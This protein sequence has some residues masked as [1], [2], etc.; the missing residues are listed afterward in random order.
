MNTGYNFYCRFDVEK[1]LLQDFSCSV[2]RRYEHGFDILLD[3]F[4]VFF[5]YEELAMHPL[6]FLV[7][8]HV[9]KN[10][11]EGDI[12]TIKNN[13]MKLLA[14]LLAWGGFINRNLYEIKI[15]YFILKENIA[16]LRKT[17]KL[18]G[19]NSIIKSLALGD[20]TA[21]SVFNGYKAVL[22]SPFSIVNEALTFVGVG[23]GLT[24]SFDDYLSGILFVDR[25]LGKNITILPDDFFE[26]IKIKTTKQ[27]VQQ[28]KY[29]NLGKMSLRFEVFLDAFLF[30]HVSVSTIL[31]LLN[32]GN[33]SGTDIL[34]G[35]LIYLENIN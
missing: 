33:T 8:A 22:S 1:L 14:D 12:V 25:V 20:M 7:P 26:K 2:S 23:E 11:Q 24:P 35:M 27:S 32:Y 28:L 9:G 18:F 5:G 17:I 30:D 31:Q 4:V 3:D 34:C 21:D 6:S 19:K 29:A 15:D 10:V 16:L 13:E